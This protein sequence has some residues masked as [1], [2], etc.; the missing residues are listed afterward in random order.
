M[1][2]GLLSAHS[3]LPRFALLERELLALSSSALLERESSVVI[4]SFLRGTG[5]VASLAAFVVV[6]RAAALGFVALG[7]LALPA[8]FAGLAFADFPL[9]AA[10]SAFAEVFALAAGFLALPPFGLVERGFLAPLPPAPAAMR[11]AMSVTASSMVT[12]S[13]A[14]SFGRVALTFPHFT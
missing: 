1:R 5:Y 8:V 2:C 14:M 6:F 11:A 13:G 7:F 4:S 10:V 3:A 9:A 12:V